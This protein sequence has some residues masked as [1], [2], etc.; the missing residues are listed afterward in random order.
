MRVPGC[1]NIKQKSDS[2]LFL[3]FFL[4]SVSSLS[5]SFL[6][7]LLPRPLLF[8]FPRWTTSSPILTHQKLSQRRT[9]QWEMWRGRIMDKKYD[10]R[11][12][13]RH[14]FCVYLCFCYFLTQHACVCHRH[15]GSVSDV[16]SET[17]HMKW[18]WRSPTRSIFH[19]AV[20]SLCHR[21]INNNYPTGFAKW[22]F[23]VQ[24]HTCKHR[25]L[26]PLHTKAWYRFSCGW[27]SAL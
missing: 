5:S 10:R 14:C 18:C 11:D 13:W 17:G 23:A 26:R 8:W 3:I 27:T 22:P 1:G 16:C 19:S 7:F 12:R 6:S 21:V 4:L 15:P 24:K 25:H 2:S 20:L 9:K